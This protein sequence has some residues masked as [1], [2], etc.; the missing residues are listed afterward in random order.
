MA[1]ELRKF[2]TSVTVYDDKVVVYPA[3]FHAPIKSLDGHNDHRIVMSLSILC[4]LTGGEI[5]GAECVD[6][7]YPAFYED[8]RKL[9]LEVAEYDAQ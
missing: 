6:K 2:G 5:I 1:E 7:S 4:T 9:G 8:L 3:D